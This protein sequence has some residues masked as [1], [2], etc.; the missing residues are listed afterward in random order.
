VGARAQ[1]IVFRAFITDGDGAADPSFT[2]VQ[3]QFR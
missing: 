1:N 2:T 3:V